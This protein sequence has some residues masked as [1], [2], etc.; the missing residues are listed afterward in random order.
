MYI[1]LTFPSAATGS[2][3][4]CIDNGLPILA[5]KRDIAAARFACYGVD[6]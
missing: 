5:E 1:T 2:Y 4:A 3:F 6:A